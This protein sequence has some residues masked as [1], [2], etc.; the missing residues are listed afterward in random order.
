MHSQGGTSTNPAPWRTPPAV[1][2]SNSR[3]RQRSIV[4]V[5]FAA[6]I[7]LDQ[8]TKWWAWRHVS[9]ARINKGGNPLVGDTVSAWYADP[10]QG[11]LLDLVGFGLLAIAIAFLWRRRQSRAVLIPGC[12]MIGGWSSNLLDRLA[13]HHLTAPGSGRGAVDFMPFNGYYYNVADLFIVCGTPLYVVAVSAACLGKL[14]GARAISVIAIAAV[15]AA[16]ADA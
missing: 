4:L 16:D 7:V 5:L 3:L 1:A 9:P 6:I 12:L 13:M 11:S 10:I 14:Q 15:G 8:A 2:E